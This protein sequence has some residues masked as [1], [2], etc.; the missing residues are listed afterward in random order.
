MSDYVL[1]LFIAGHSSRSE[2]AVANLRRA[3]ALANAPFDLLIV[4]VLERPESAE[5]HKIL[6]TPTLVKEK[7]PPCRR[8]IGDLSNLDALLAELNITPI[9]KEGSRHD[10]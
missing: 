6:A 10:S 3:S 9:T 7:P 5:E 2:R 1:K 4:D 8:I